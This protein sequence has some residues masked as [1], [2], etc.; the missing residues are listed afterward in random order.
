MTPLI[1]CLIPGLLPPAAEAQEWPLPPDTPLLSRW[2]KQQP[3]VPAWNDPAQLAHRILLPGSPP[4]AASAWRA[5]CQRDPSLAA[6]LTLPLASEGGSIARLSPV[7]LQTGID[8]AVVLGERFLKLTP[9]EFDQLSTDLNRWLAA[10][11]LHLLATA[12]GQWYLVIP[13][14]SILG[15]ADLPPLGDAL[16][17]SA[18][19]FIEGDARRSLR[20]WLTE[21]QMWLY[22]H[23]INAA[24]AARGAPELNSLWLWAR[25]ALPCSSPAARPT[26]P[27][28]DQTSGSLL[29]DLPSLAGAW[30]GT[31]RL[32]PPLTA[33]T[34]LHAAHA[35][36]APRVHLVWTE[37]GYAALEGDFTG[38]QHA[39]RRVEQ[40]LTDLPPAWRNRFT[41]DLGQ[42]ARPFPQW[43]NL[44]GALR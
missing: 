21:L 33:E 6:R 30:P 11:G 2:L 17:R 41:L 12:T 4:S 34:L 28:A 18:H 1:H 26:A 10:D 39:H 16:N 43:R 22:A 15:E 25:A 38:W 37:P 44:W 9:E 32:M 7:H 24:R 31:A 36:P 20:R 8:T 3:P 42:G 5:E 13:A 29:T 19:P 35:T 23:P 27:A 40:L 14:H